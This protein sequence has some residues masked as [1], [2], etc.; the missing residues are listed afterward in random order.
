MK[1]AEQLA[2]YASNQLVKEFQSKTE[3]D[4]AAQA[5]EVVHPEPS[6]VVTLELKAIDWTGIPVSKPDDEKDS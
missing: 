1:E 5:Y 3:A 6:V 2:N 4:S